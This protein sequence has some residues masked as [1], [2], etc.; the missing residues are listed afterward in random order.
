[1]LVSLP[2]QTISLPFS[3]RWLKQLFYL[4]LFIFLLFNFFCFF[5]SSLVLEAFLYFPLYFE[6]YLRGT[7]SLKSFIFYFELNNTFKKFLFLISM[8]LHYSLLFLKLTN[9]MAITGSRAQ[10]G[11]NHL[12]PSRTICSPVCSWLYFCKSKGFF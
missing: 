9:L 5:I 7:L 2:F 3:F 11:D 10:G 4:S 6:Y 1:M 12:F 8:L